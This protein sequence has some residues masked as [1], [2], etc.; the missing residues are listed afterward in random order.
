[1]KAL[2]NYKVGLYYIIGSLLLVTLTLYFLKGNVLF[3]L[4]FLALISLPILLFNYEWLIF[5]I[6]FAIPF[7][8]THTFPNGF[9]IELFSEPLMMLFTGIFG[10]A[11]ILNPKNLKN[12]Y[13]SLITLFLIL[14]LIG[15]IINTIDSVNMLK[16]IKYTLAKSWFILPF[17]IF[18][19]AYCGN[20]L[21]NFKVIYWFCLI[22]YIIIITFITIKHLKIGI[23]FSNI[24]TPLYP[25]F[26]NHVAYSSAIAV[27]FPFVLVSISWY[28]KNSKTRK[29]IIYTVIMMLF[30]IV[31][32][33]TRATWLAIILAI[34][35]Y[36]I[37][38]YKFTKKTLLTLLIIIPSILIYLIKDN[39]YL[40]YAPD[41]TTTIYNHEDLEKHLEA[42]YQ[43]KDV[44]GVERLYRWVAAVNMGIK[45][46]IT[47]TGPGTFYPE[48]KNYTSEQFKTYVSNNIE[49]STAHNYFLLLWA[50]QGII[51][52]SLFLILIS[53]TLIRG[54]KLYHLIQNEYEK[55][56]LLASLLS[57][58]ILIVHLF[59]NELIEV[60]KIGSWFFVSL[61]IITILDQKYFYSK[62]SENIEISST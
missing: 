35:Y 7:S 23:S 42:T 54:E 18:I 14:F 5:A 48:Y 10:M 16:S 44:S 41:Y 4:P 45:N 61:A 50:E 38:K 8:Y 6:F 33:V 11:F 29:I 19:I 22:A 2:V 27:F 17:F 58:F 53:Y 31:I 55:S 56:L 26:L 34:P 24:N 49:Q 62:N 47:G 46:P 59:L 3:W 32:S 12:G 21:E 36:F 13:K 28:K 37:I 52:L 9:S 57:I 1:L 51:G 20:K 25:F 40:N 30:A 43:M 15:F 39:N 60:D